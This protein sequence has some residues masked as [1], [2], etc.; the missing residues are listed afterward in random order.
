[1][2]AT[3]PSLD[4]LLQRADQAMYTAKQAGRNCWKLWGSTLTTSH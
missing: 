3:T 2:N 4:V 1:M